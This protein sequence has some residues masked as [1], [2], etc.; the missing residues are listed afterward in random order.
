M[1]LVVTKLLI[2]A[3]FATLA[4]IPSGEGGAPEHAWTVFLVGA[5][6]SGLGAGGLSPLVSTIMLQAADPVVRGRVLGAIT[7]LACVLAPAFTL[8]SGVAVPVIGTDAVMAVLA[9][10]ILAAVAVLLVRR[11][12]IRETDPA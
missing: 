7:I 2:A 9:A 8:A 3:G 11:T 5:F 4:L 10:I 6:L 12:A 1:V